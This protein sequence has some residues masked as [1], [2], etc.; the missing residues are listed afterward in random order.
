[1]D[2]NYYAHPIDVA[3]H[4]ASVRLARRMLTSDPL[5]EFFISEFEPGAEKTSDAQIENWLRANVTSDNHET[6]SNA[7]LPVELGGVVDTSLKVY[8]TAN[9]RVAG[10]YFSCCDKMSGLASHL[11]NGRCIDHSLSNQRPHCEFRLLS[12]FLLAHANWNEVFHCLRD[13]GTCSRYHKEKS[14]NTFNTID[15]VVL[16]QCDT[17]VNVHDF[18][19]KADMCCILS[20][21]VVFSYSCVVMHQLNVW[22]QI[23]RL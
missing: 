15:G 12:K 4:V 6:G 14:M 11:L 1:M 10:T 21:L 7:M 16:E 19:K 13:R 9:V 17:Y 18:Y 22:E 8:G 5:G 2:P 23:L 20:I 3:A